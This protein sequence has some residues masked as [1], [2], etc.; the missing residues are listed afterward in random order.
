MFQNVF[1][2]SYPS[3]YSFPLPYLALSANGGRGEYVHDT[4]WKI[5]KNILIK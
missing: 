5:L 1:N 4:V 2:V 3:P